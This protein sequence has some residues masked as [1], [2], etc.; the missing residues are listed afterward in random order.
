[1]RTGGEEPAVVGS[2]QRVLEQ[3]EVDVGIARRAK[4]VGGNRYPTV[5][6]GICGG[7]QKDVVDVG[8]AV[9]LADGPGPIGWVVSPLQSASKDDVV[10]IILVDEME[11]GYSV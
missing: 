3:L 5:T 8:F 11:R 2:D 6:V 1:M 4:P 7:V 10:A 9:R